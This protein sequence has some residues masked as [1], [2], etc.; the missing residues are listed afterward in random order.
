MTGGLDTQEV[1]LYAEWVVAPHLIISP[2]V[3]FYMPDY[4]AAE[5]A[6]DRQR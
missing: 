2:L 6:A 3:A 1:N 5:G 4:S